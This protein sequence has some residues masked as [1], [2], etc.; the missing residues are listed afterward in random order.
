MA[1]R[2]GLG[3]LCAARG[4]P[5][6]VSLLSLHLSCYHYALFAFLVTSGGCD[7]HSF[8]GEHGPGSHLWFYRCA[9]PSLAFCTA[10]L[11]R[12]RLRGSDTRYAYSCAV[13][14]VG[15]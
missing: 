1:R 11:D 13:A 3:L 4:C 8:R 15:L 12:Y 5:G 2:S 9:W 7:D 14:A 10:A 6:G